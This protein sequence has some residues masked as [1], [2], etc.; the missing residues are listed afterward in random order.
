LLIISIIARIS[1]FLTVRSSDLGGMGSWLIAAMPSVSPALGPTVSELGLGTTV[2]L[3]SFVLDGCPALPE[4]FKAFSSI[5][6]DIDVKVL[7]T[8]VFFVLA[9]VDFVFSGCMVV[10]LI[11]C[12]VVV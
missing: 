7:S 2:S 8:G 1:L 12:S 11:L 10:R 9:I 4:D 5:S 3:C 6:I